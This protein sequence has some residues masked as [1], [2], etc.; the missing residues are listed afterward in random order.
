[1]VK[2][3]FNE[4][5]SKCHTAYCD[6]KDRAVDFETVEYLKQVPDEN[7]LRTLLKKL[8]LPAIEMIRKSEP[9]FIEQYSNHN[10]TEEACIQ[11]II[12]HPILMQ[13]PIVEFDNR[14]Y[15]V[16]PPVTVEEILK[17]QI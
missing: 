16:R 15:I 6:L 1:M 17:K 12:Q 3:Y 11:A 8:Q 7:S 14:A 2:I 9:I 5:C 4:S 13:R 10:L